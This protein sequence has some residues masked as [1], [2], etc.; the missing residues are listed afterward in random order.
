MEV[1]FVDAA[2]ID[3]E[4]SKLIL[5]RLLGAELNLSVPFFFSVAPVCDIPE[6][7]LR[8]SP[9]VRQNG[10]WRDRLAAEVC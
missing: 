4:V 2:G 9:S 6:K 10:V 5:G 3:P 1:P 8:V 7:N